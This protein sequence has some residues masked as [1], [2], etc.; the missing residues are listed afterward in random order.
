MKEGK[1]RA[2]K[3]LH[4]F[5][6]NHLAYLT[7]S[8]RCLTFSNAPLGEGHSHVE[9]AHWKGYIE[10]GRWWR[11]L[12]TRNDAEKLDYATAHALSRM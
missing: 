8:T 5:Q 1:Q 12:H 7:S 2:S 4:S 11:I 10:Q 9:K 3:V 6:D